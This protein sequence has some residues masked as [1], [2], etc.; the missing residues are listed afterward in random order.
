MEEEEEEEE[1]EGRAEPV[2]SRAVRTLRVRA[3]WRQ[4]TP[5]QLSRP[6]SAALLHHQPVNTPSDDGDRLHEQRF[7]LPH[8]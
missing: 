3:S 2:Q 4:K 6:A 1:E 8:M 7:P 5:A